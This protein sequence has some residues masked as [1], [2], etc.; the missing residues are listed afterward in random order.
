MA[1]IAFTERAAFALIYRSEFDQVSRHILDRRNIET[2]GQLFGFWTAHGVPVVLFALGP[3]PKANHQSTF[4]NQDID[5]LLQV[6][7]ILTERYGLQHIGEWHSHHQLG[8]A[9]PS[10][11]DVNTM[12]SSMVHNNLGRFLMALGNCDETTSVLN[13]F[14]FAQGSE[15]AYRQMPW[16]I[17]EIDSPFRTVIE[18][19]TE[20]RRLI[21]EPKTKTASHGREYTTGDAVVR[22]VPFYPEGYWLHQPENNLILKKIVDSLSAL[23]D[24]GKCVV[25]LTEAHFVELNLVRADI[26]ERIEFTGEFPLAPPLVEI[27]GSRV[28]NGNDDSWCLTKDVA[29]DFFE[30]YDAIHVKKGGL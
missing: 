8:L 27:C 12:V 7:S 20:L 15:T 14:E 9:R 26:A 1:Q 21:V 4:F 6:G 2:G 3:G 10:G 25:R 13:A 23:S 24:D 22:E 29:K 18:D 28:R 16:K 11:H 30:Y 19:D 17:K 5:Y